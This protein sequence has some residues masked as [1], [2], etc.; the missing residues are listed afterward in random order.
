[1]SRDAGAAESRPDLKS[2]GGRNGEHGVREQGLELVETGLAQADRNIADHAGYRTAD[3]VLFALG[4]EDALWEG[5][6]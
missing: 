4:F 1:M 2:L 6:G 5:S 3:G